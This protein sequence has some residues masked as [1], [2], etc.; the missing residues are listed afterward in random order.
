MVRNSL[1][2]NFERLGF[3]NYFGVVH[4]VIFSVCGYCILTGTADATLAA[5]VLCIPLLIL[6]LIGSLDPDLAGKFIC[7]L[8][9]QTGAMR[10]V[11]I[12]LF[13]SM[14]VWGIISVSLL[15]GETA[16]KAIGL[17]SLAVLL[18]KIDNTFICKANKE[19]GLSDAVSYAY[20]A[21]AASIAAGL[22]FD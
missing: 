20:I 6:G 9:S 15:S 5:K 8:P 16:F 17:A 4:L 10:T 1:N 19:L 18:G 2:N 3:I 13:Q 11:C 7:D 21:S 12:W 22:L 14:L